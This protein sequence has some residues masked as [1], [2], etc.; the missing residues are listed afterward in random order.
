MWVGVIAQLRELCDSHCFVTALCLNHQN[1]LWPANQMNDG[2]NYAFFR[3]VGNIFIVIC[4]YEG[5]Q[6]KCMQ[7]KCESESYQHLRL[8]SQF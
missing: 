3:I 6:R 1:Q 4:A 8:C 2:Y 7:S 5:N